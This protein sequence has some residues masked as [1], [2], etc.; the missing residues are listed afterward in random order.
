MKYLAKTENPSPEGWEMFIGRWQ[1]WHVGH[2]WLIDQQLNRGKKV[3]VAIRNMQPSEK[4]PFMV[5]DVYLNVCEELKDLIAEGKVIVSNIPDIA[6]INIGREV[7][8]DII[9]HEPPTE[10][11]EISATKIREEMKKKGKL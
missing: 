3:W 10:I 9:E 1:P 8:Y 7:G 4:N 5:D 2:R 6:S 11:K